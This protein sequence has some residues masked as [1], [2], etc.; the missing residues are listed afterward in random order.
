M[1][2]PKTLSIEDDERVNVIQPFAV[3]VKGERVTVLPRVGPGGRA[4]GY[5]TDADLGIFF[6]RYPWESAHIIGIPA[7]ANTNG[8]GYGVHRDE[9]LLVPSANQAKGKGPEV[10]DGRLPDPVVMPV[11]APNI[12]VGACRSRRPF[13]RIGDGR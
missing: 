9:Y 10:H 13:R 6:D 12:I 11:E 7:D 1:P 5:R 3:G 8:R 4:G 2:T